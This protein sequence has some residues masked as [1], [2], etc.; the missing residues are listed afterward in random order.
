M[1][2]ASH[3]LVVIGAGPGGYVAAIRASQLGLNV[4]CVELE[5]ALGG[6]C[7]RIGCIPSKALLESS[8]RYHETRDALAV[9]GVKVGQVELDLPTML[10]RKDEVV[11]GRT[12]GVDFLFK[13]NKITRYTGV[14]TIDG[15]GGV[16]VKSGPQ[17]TTLAAKNILIATGSKP[18]SLP[19]VEWS[20]DKIG[21]STEALSYASVPKHLVVI[22]AGYIGLELGSV[23]LRLGAKVTVVEYLDRILPGMDSEIA[24]EGQKLLE[25]QGME[26][27]LHQKVTG[28]RVKGKD[29]VVECEGQEPIKADRVLV[30]VGRAPNTEGLGL[31]SVGVQVDERGRVPVDAHYQAADGVYAIGDVIGG[32]MLAHKAEEEGVACVEGIVTGYGHVDYD[33]IPGVV[34]TQPEIATVGRSEDELKTEG[35]AYRRGV[36]FFRANA[37][38][39]ALGQIDGRVK[40]LADAAT[41]RIVGVHIIGP[42]AGDMIAEAVAA[43]EFG[44]TSEDI[45]RTC[46]AH[47]TLAEALKEAAL[48]VDGRAIHS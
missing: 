13:K 33:A 19:G 20:G 10:K 9:H 27:R 48:A 24:R 47:P 37:R 2:D 23:W 39:H 7:L 28:A 8:E 22:G 12:Q 45:A 43:M 3:D 46:H 31:A 17:T 16:R 29:C 25:R 34:Y 30:A 14:A 44:A 38:A 41:D 5:E 6:T 11:R 26:I 42:R 35:V 15:P 18:A 21:S 1:A 36:F 40:V 4:G 32:A